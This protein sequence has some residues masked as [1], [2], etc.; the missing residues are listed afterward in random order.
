VL[1]PQNDDGFNPA[2]L[3]LDDAD[4]VKKLL[5]E[6]YM[7]EF[8]A[9]AWPTIETA[10]FKPNWHIDCIAEHLEAVVRGEI[11]KLLVN[12]PPRHSKSNMCS[13]AL[14][15]WVWAQDDDPDDGNYRDYPAA[16]VGPKTKFLFLSYSNGLSLDHSRQTRK[17]IGS[18]WYQS[19][20]T[21]FRSPARRTPR[22]GSISCRVATASPRRSA[23]RRPVAVATLSSASLTMRSSGLPEA[24]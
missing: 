9:N 7:A 19:G 20:A 6:R 22:R 5:S 12:I 13:I 11:K 24:R 23:V 16:L 8:M 18:D 21:G 1:G 14:P 10:A 17:L 2:E 4:E 15:S 3:T